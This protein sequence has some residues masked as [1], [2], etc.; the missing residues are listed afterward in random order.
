[1]RETPKKAATAT[2]FVLPLNAVEDVNSHRCKSFC[3]RIDASRNSYAKAMGKLDRLKA[4]RTK[5]GQGNEKGCFVGGRGA[6]SF[7]SFRVR[8]RHAG[9]GVEGS[10]RRAVTVGRR[11]W[12]CVHHRL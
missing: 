9:E 1:R 4:D 7:W 2:V 3:V 5:K 10:G 11:V 12:H 6:R 8:G